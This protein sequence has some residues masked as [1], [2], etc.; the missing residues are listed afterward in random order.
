MKSVQYIVIRGPLGCGKTTLSEELAKLLNA[1]HIAYDRILDEF[2]LTEDKEEGYISQKSFFRANE[3]AF[4]RAKNFLD[5]GK[6]VIFDGNFYWKSQVE[7]LI[8][9]LKDYSGKV[10]TLKSSLETCIDRDSKRKKVHGPIAAKV[11]HK[12][13]TSFSHGI[14]IDNDGKSVKQTIDEIRKE[15]K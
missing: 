5:K 13:S 14:V 10:F 15:L 9:K 2:E 3:I 6:L 7:D 11:V 12:K 1:E 8:S 4:E